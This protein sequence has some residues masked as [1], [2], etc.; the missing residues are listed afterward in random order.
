M[1]VGDKIILK[2]EYG[3]EKDGF[4]PAGTEGTIVEIDEEFSLLT[5]IVDFGEF[6]RSVS[7]KDISKMRAFTNLLSVEDEEWNEE[8]LRMF[9]N[10]YW[11]VESV[12]CAP[13]VK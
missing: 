1:N 2:Y 11:I 4:V 13:V 10:G 5:Y 6:N 12:D 9:S 7:E 3:N 8:H